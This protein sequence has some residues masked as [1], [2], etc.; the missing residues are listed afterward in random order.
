MVHVPNLPMLT[1]VE[2]HDAER[3]VALHA[4]VVRRTVGGASQRRT[5][6]K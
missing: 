1:A 5:Q 6:K 4:S 3:S 2:G